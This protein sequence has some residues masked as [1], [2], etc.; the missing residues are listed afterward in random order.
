MNPADDYKNKN[1][2]DRRVRSREEERERREGGGGCGV[3]CFI[4]CM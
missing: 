2:I 1:N 4:V 3:G